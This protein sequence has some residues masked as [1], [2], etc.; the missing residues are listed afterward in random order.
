MDPAAEIFEWARAIYS[1]GL[2]VLGG[3]FVWIALRFFPPL[4]AALTNLSAVVKHIPDDRVRAARQLELTEAI[5]DKLGVKV[6]P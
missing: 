3:L 6:D 5:A 4:I 2:L 1:L